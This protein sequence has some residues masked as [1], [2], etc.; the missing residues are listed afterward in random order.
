MKP[1]ISTGLLILSMSIYGAYAFADEMQSNTTGMQGNP[2]GMPNTTGIPGSPPPAIPVNPP[3]VSDTNNTQSTPTTDEQGD[4]LKCSGFA[5]AAC[6]DLVKD[7]CTKYY[8]S[9]SNDG[10][11]QCT[12]D[13]SQSTP[14]CSTAKTNCSQE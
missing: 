10:N 11:H 1:I 6:E 5:I 8:L 14:V 4:M 7:S 9:V 2:N 3:G 12:W 13:E